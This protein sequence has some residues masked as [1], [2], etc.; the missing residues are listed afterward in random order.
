MLNLSGSAAQSC[1]NVFS[2]NTFDTTVNKIAMA[3]SADAP[4]F[5]LDGVSE[6]RF[7]DNVVRVDSGGPLIYMI[8]A[9]HNVFTRQ[10]LADIRPEG[11]SRGCAWLTDG[12]SD[13]AFLD[14]RL[15]ST[16]QSGTVLITGGSDR[17]TLRD[18]TFISGGAPMVLADPG[19]VVTI[20][21]ERRF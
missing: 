15:Q 16:N 18:C 21:G 13:N 17:T 3:R 4:G 8:G 6:A 11:T 5:D 1:G 10:T 9:S 19:L 12:S 2:G 7:A 20:T 14:D